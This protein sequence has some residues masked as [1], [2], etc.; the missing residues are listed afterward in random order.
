MRAPDGRHTGV[1]SILGYIELEALRERDTHEGFQGPLEIV[2][3]VVAHD[4][5]SDGRRWTL[6]SWWE[7]TGASRRRLLH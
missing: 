2:R 1:G 3:A 7:S 5:N 6:R 4:N